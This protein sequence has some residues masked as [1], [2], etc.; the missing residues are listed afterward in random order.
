M[1]LTL[2]QVILVSDTNKRQPEDA[3]VYV[4]QHPIEGKHLFPEWVLDGTAHFGTKEM[5]QRYG[6]IY[7]DAGERWCIV[8]DVWSDNDAMCAKMW[9]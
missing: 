1:Y 3:T 2:D 7:M 6:T 5:M 4:K 9:I 8:P